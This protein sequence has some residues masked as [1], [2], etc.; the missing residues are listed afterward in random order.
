MIISETPHRSNSRWIQAGALLLAVAILPLGSALAGED[1]AKKAR[2]RGAEARIQAAVDAGDVTPEQG[3]EKLAGIHRN[4]FGAE[5]RVG[6]VEKRLAAM[7]EAGEISEAD[8]E[9][10]LAGLKEG[11][12]HRERG[13][14]ARPDIDD[15]VRRVRAAV[16]A[17]DI[18]P[19][20]ARERMAAYRAS[21]GKQAL[22]GEAAKIRAAV[23]AGELTPE[24][25]REQ[26]QG[27]RKR[28]AE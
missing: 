17:G 10:R 24:E 13:G 7:V 18:T 28:A 25:A 15:A 8:A 26:L 11:L 12:T 23:Q 14:D 27:L 4:L 3:Q 9:A 22:R 16:Q 5:M 1:D 6:A 19:E 21:T 2:Y 20:Q